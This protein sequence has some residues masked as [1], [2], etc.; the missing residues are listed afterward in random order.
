VGL[1]GDIF[2]GGVGQSLRG[3]VQKRSPAG[4]L[5]FSWTNSAGQRNGHQ[6]NHLA[7]D[8]HGDVYLADV[9]N[10]VQKFDTRGHLVWTYPRAGPQRGSSASLWTL[11][12]APDGTA[13]FPDREHSRILKLSAEGRLVGAFHGQWD[14]LSADLHGTLYGANVAHGLVEA[15][16]PN[17]RSERHWLIETSPGVGVILSIANGADGSVYVLERRQ[18]RKGSL[19]FEV[20]RYSPEGRLTVAF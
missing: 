14:Y 12:V 6:V 2:M 9:D 4:K 13:Y 10:I 3:E 1:L 15:F 7:L 8:R 19:G 20:A 5:L 16:A 18:S 17:G 11:A